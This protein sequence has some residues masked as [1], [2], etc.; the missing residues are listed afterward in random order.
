MNTYLRLL[1]VCFWMLPAQ[2]LCTMLG[3]GVFVLLTVVE[4]MPGIRGVF[5]RLFTGVTIASVPLFFLGGAFWRALSAPRAVTLAPHGRAKLLAAVLS[6]AMTFLLLWVACIG[7]SPF[8]YRLRYGYRLMD[9]WSQFVPAFAMAT[10]WAVATFIAS[11]SPLAGLCVLLLT[12]C[13]VYVLQLFGIENTAQLWRHSWGVSA[14]VALWFAFGSWYL[15]TRRIRPPGWLLP[16]GASPLTAVAAPGTARQIGFTAP[17]AL[18]HLLLGGAG[19]WRVVLQWLLASSTLLAVLMV[20]GRR[21]PTSA[22]FAAHAA[23][24][25]LIICPAVV[26]AQS[27]AMVRRARALWLLSGYSRQQL[28]SFTERT[29]FKFAA[30]MA[31]V[32]AGFLLVLWYTQPWRPAVT[33]PQALCVVVVPLLLVAGQALS[34]PHGWDSYWRWPAMALVCWFLTWIPLTATNP[35]TWAGS[36]GWV[37]IAVTLGIAIALRT[38]A[39]LRWLEEDLPRAAAA[40]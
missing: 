1:W 7:F 35:V 2:R 6:I 4:P 12:I 15:R 31:L 32:F 10:W 16:G 21:D 30:A 25:A 26:A 17:A 23:F 8:D 20:L 39:Q 36:R 37:W 5:G 3:G 29:V 40:P 33:L 14:P 18:E 13:S 24:A 27:L 11:R 34:R 28:F 38:L 9:Y 22:I 19:V